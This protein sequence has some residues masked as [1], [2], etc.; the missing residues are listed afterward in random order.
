MFVKTLI[1]GPF[2]IEMP[3]S[4]EDKTCTLELRKLS[5]ELIKKFRNWRYDS[6]YDKTS[7]K[8]LL[9]LPRSAS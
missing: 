7:I 8:S 1:A 6:Y 4:E 5:V 9:H 3:M 2:M